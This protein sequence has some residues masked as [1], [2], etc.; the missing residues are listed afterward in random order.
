MITSPNGTLA[1]GSTLRGSFSSI[2]VLQVNITVDRCC[3][4]CNK[5][6]VDKADA[7]ELMD[8]CLIPFNPHIAKVWERREDPILP[9]PTK[10]VPKITIT[11]ERQDNVGKAFVAYPN[12]TCVHFTCKDTDTEHLTEL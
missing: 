10:M 9:N 1:T 3:P 6:F 5:R 12:E 7:A 11:P 8:R 4:V 2:S